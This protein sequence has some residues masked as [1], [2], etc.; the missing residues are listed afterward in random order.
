MDYRIT[1]GDGSTIWVH[2]EAQLIRDDEGRPAYWQGSYRRHGAR[3]GDR[4][5]P[6][7]EERYRQIV[8]HTPV[9]T[10]PGAAHRRRAFTRLDVDVLREPPGRGAPRLPGRSDGPSPG[11]GRA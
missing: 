7:A 1:A 3:R 4:A 10:V 11:S 6:V 5:D 9:I 8:E 2:D